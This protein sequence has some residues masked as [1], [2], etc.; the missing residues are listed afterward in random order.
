MESSSPKRVLVLTDRT[1]ATPA[2]IGAIQARVQQ[3]PAQFRVLVPNPA[4]TEWHPIHP[5]RH[6]QAAEAERVLTA[7]L[8]VV[9]AAAGGRVIGSVSIRHDPMD[10]V[11]ETILNEPVDE[12]IISM[13][14]HVV[15]RWLHVDLPHRLAHLGLPIT[16]VSEEQ[17]AQAG[18]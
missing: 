15:E 8:P 9:E 4:P 17:P 6:E 12:I 10:A 16:T 3:G 13:A 18:S 1:A 7:A 5:K 11:E 14:P 2:L